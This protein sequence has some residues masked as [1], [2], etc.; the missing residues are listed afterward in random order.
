MPIT[1]I[2]QVDSGLSLLLSQFKDKA[3]I[4]GV[5]RTYLN[6]SQ[7]TQEAYEE[8]LDERN[9]AVAEGVQLDQLGAIVGEGRNLRDD[10]AYRLAI[11]IKIAINTN[12]GTLPDVKAIIK[13]FTGAL[14]VRILEHYPA[15]VYVYV[16]GGT[17]L[18]SLRELIEGVLPASVSLGYIGYSSENEPLPFTPYTEII[19]V[20]PL[21]DYTGDIFVT[22][23]GEELETATVLVNLP[24]FNSGV[25]EELEGQPE[26]GFGICA[27]FI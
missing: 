8:M 1:R 3:N 22:D 21:V 23:T 18:K 15:S 26:Q 14:E 27:E 16:R 4:D 12:K 7:Q 11:K 25:L 2:N 9:L 6:A 10:E 13:L 24:V 17:N 20:Q 19:E 5:L